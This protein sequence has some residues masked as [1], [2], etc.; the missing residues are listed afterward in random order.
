MARLAHRNTRQSASGDAIFQS[1]WVSAV[2]DPDGDAQ[3]HKA[4]PVRGTSELSWHLQGI[5]GHM[6]ANGKTVGALAMPFR[7][8]TEV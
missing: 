2:E 7:W 4:M 5:S 3:T 8:T 1:W 6:R